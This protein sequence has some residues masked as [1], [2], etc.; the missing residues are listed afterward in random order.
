MFPIKVLVVLSVCNLHFRIVCG[1]GFLGSFFWRSH[2]CLLELKS[3]CCVS[4]CATRNKRW[5]SRLGLGEPL[6]KQGLRIINSV[7]FWCWCWKGS[8][9]HAWT[10][11]L[12]GA[13]A[14]GKR[15]WQRQSLVTLLVWCSPR[16][17]SLGKGCPAVCSSPAATSHRAQ[18]SN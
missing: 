3:S 13:C 7:P 2:C 5:G 15:L 18:K 12:C 4:G 11:F 16:A 1:V 8:C 10:G 6:W 14:A 9:C 17:R